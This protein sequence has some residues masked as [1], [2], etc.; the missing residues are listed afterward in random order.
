M[1]EQE[2]RFRAGFVPSRE[3][4]RESYRAVFR[5]S[6]RAAAY[7]ALAA[8]CLGMALY[9]AYWIKV[10]LDTGYGA[11]RLPVYAALF[12][13]MAAY[14]VALLLFTPALAARGYMRRLAAIHGGTEGLS[15]AYAFGDEGVRELDSTGA[16]VDTAY[17]QI[18][19]VYETERCVVLRRRMRVFQVVDK[20]SVQGGS[21]RE[22][23]AFLQEK[24]P[25]ARFHW[26]RER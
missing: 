15:V 7:I 3:L 21:L 24:I 23:R 19:A 10:F 8:F 1:E 14:P 20:G 2:A 12:L 13:A 18:R 9:C 16:K 11:G 25:A 5:H 17:G 4:M 22:F 26:K 6:W